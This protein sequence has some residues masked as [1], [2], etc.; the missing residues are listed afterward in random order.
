[1]EVSE[2]RKTLARELVALKGMLNDDAEK[3]KDVIRQFADETPRLLQELRQ[4]IVQGHW[5]EA[6]GMAHKLK[7]RYAYLGMDQ[8]VVELAAW[9]DLFKQGNT[10]ANVNQALD[11]LDKTTNEVIQELRLSHHYHNDSTAAELPLQGKCVLV[12]ED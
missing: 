6:E 12:A 9:E 8:I 2:I 4:Q 3:L 11:R 10:L 7:T 5:R 1:M